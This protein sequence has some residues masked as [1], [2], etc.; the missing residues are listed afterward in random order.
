MCGRYTLITNTNFYKRFSIL[1]ED[2]SIDITS[3]YNVSPG[4]IMPVIISNSPNRVVMMKWG[5][6]PYWAKDPKVG[7]KMIN[8][9]ADSVSSKPSFKTSFKSR[10]CLVPASG[11]YEWQ[12]NGN[13]KTPYYFKAKD[14]ELI[15]FAGLYD[16]W[17]DA[18]GKE[19]LTYTIIT[20]NANEY[21]KNIH[22]RMPVI[23]SRNEEKTWLDTNINENILL[24]LLD[25]Y[26]VNSIEA[27]VV[28][29]DV[30]S[31]ANNTPTLV[32]PAN[33]IS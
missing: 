29:S 24:K 18:Q 5:L 26:P 4:R 11:F 20:T 19:I 10:R 21:V 13:K 28:S 27:F 33:T 31:P 1:V 12:K 6:I 3:N 25:P 17:K 16:I 8:A 7:Y 9:R 22:D 30:N 15:A 2:S 23:L 14:E 32:K